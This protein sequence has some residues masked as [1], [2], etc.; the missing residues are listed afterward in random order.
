MNFEIA[1]LAVTIGQ[2]NPKSWIDI[3][4]AG[5]TPIIA[6]VTTFIA[7]Q[8]WITNERKRKQDLFDKRYDNLFLPILKN[9]ENYDYYKNNETT[10][11][12]Y[13]VIKEKNEK[14]HYQLHKYKFLIKQKDFKKIMEL[15]GK[16]CKCLQEETKYQ[17][18]NVKDDK[19]TAKTI[20]EDLASIYDKIESIITKYLLIEEDFFMNN[21]FKE[22]VYKIESCFQNIR[23]RFRE[24]T[25]TKEYEVEQETITIN[26]YPIIDNFGKFLPIALVLFVLFNFLYNFFYFLNFDLALINLLKLSD[27]YEGGATYFC[28]FCI[29]ITF[30]YLFKS[31]TTKIISVMIDLL[32]YVLA[33]FF[34][35][36]NIV[37]LETINLIPFI[38]T[39]CIILSLFLKHYK[40]TILSGFIN[41]LLA[42]LLFANFNFLLNY[43]C[44]TNQ[45]ITNTNKSFYL[46]R[47]ISDGA[48]VKNKDGNLIFFKWDKIANIE[49]SVPIEAN[50]IVFLGNKSK[51]INIT[52]KRPK[53]IIFS[54][55]LINTKK[56][57]E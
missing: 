17:T 32:I 57:E 9:A 35:F 3:L 40:K 26:I 50:I 1:N 34:V 6:I 2:S 11:I 42:L 51:K 10:N 36:V 33:I 5:L 38:V 4:S 44:Y 13:Q 45:V 52:N 29:F 39:I 37:N 23:N 41:I 16:L 46:V 14:L 21:F 12:D 49:Y 56:E 31:K 48:L 22:I 25:K 43:N 55:T 54:E 19:T 28:T 47:Q 27:Y 30:I 53:T 18:G 20:Y 7:W 15:H 24:K 8:Q